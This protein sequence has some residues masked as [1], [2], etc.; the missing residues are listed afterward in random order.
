MYRD[1]SNQSGDMSEQ[2]VRLDLIKKGY[3]VLDPSSRDAIYDLVVDRGSGVFETVQ[4]KTMSNNS[5]TKIVDRSGE[6]VS[7]NGK[8]RNSQDYAQHKIDWLA[9]VNKQGEVYYYKLETYSKINK[10]SFSVKKHPQ[11]GFPVRIVPSR[12]TKKLDKQ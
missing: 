4:A 3:I 12:H 8:T 11:D 6:K 7:A 10:K 1:S 9:G 5:I 2:I